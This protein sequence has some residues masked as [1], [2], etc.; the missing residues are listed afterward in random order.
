MAEMHHLDVQAK[1]T[2]Y[3]Y[4]LKVTDVTFNLPMSMI[5]NVSFMSDFGKLKSKHMLVKCRHVGPNTV[6]KST[7][8]HKTSILVLCRSHVDKLKIRYVSV[9]F[10][11][12]TSTFDTMSMRE[13]FSLLL[14][15]S[16]S[17]SHE[18]IS[19]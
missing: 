7:F 4:N 9:K 5:L 13:F 18:I 14:M 2:R 10:R 8:V 17:I 16:Y 12:H 19:Y 1:C 11:R 15:K 6:K 3:T